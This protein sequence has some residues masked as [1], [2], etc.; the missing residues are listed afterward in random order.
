MAA[1][2]SVASMS[3]GLID[4]MASKIS[5]MT[6]SATVEGMARQIASTIYNIIKDNIPSLALATSY[7]AAVG[8]G[9]IDGMMAKVDS[10]AATAYALGRTIDEQMRLAL[11]IASPSKA[12]LI[13]GGS[14]GGAV[15]LG[16]EGQI[17]AV[18]AAALGL[19][20]AMGIGGPELA[21][22]GV[23]QQMMVVRHEVAV[24]SPDGSVSGVDMQRL[25]DRLGPYVRDGIRGRRY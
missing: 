19:A 16:M 22:A 15:A 7:G 23:P 18:R 21:F 12:G 20:G 1:A 9:L 4:G 25:A 13:A 11:G 14:Y 17:G 10:V 2:A 5:G 6:G 3:T 8:Q 24:S